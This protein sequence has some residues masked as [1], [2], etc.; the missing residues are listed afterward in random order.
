V[1]RPFKNLRHLRLPGPVSFNHDEILS[2]IS[3]KLV[4]LDVLV[5]LRGKYPPPISFD[6]PCLSNL[7]SLTVTPAPFHDFVMSHGSFDETVV[8]RSIDLVE[9]V[10]TSLP[11]L[12]ELVLED[13][14]LDID[15]IQCLG[16][17]RKLKSLIW[18]LSSG[19]ICGEEDPECVLAKYL[20]LGG[21]E[22]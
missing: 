19:L 21:C 7:Q 9:A 16:K 8:A 12:G 20:N 14:G 5:G 17:L 13:T 15:R 6:H 1:L 22:A 3:S 10:T 4:S 11:D 2:R 18:V